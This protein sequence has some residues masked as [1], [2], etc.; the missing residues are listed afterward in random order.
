M[1]VV[2][3]FVESPTNVF[4]EHT[5]FGFEEL[6]ADVVGDNYVHL[7]DGGTWSPIAFPPGDAMA[8]TPDEIISVAAD[9]AGGT[10]FARH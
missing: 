9:E 2:F 8:V 6:Y 5:G 10:T 1:P 3:L 7:W 4:L